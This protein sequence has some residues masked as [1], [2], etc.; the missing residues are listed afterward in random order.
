MNTSQARSRALDIISARRQHSRQLTESRRKELMASVEGLAEL[1]KEINNAGIAALHSAVAG[2]AGGEKL[3]RDVEGLRAKQRELLKS[4]GID[5]HAL[6]PQY[7]CEK[8]RDTGFLP[9]GEMCGCLHELI[10]RILREDINRNSPLELSTFDDFSLDYYPEKTEYY[11]NGD[12]NSAP[13]VRYP[14]RDAKYNLDVC[15]RFAQK[16]PECGADLLLLGDAGL[17]KTHLALAIANEVIARGYDVIYCSSA[18]ALRR[19]EEERLNRELEG[20]TLESLKKCSLLIF[21]DLG[22]EYVNQYTLSVLYDLI[23]SRRGARRLTVYTTNLIAE[24][25]MMRRYGE[26]IS[27]RLEGGCVMLPFTGDDIRI[28]LGRRA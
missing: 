23:N 13:V 25:A 27:S 24:G 17:G 3:T 11:P 1:E 18:A 2:N 8:C 14:R 19:I 12:K 16:F 20:G 10:G 28:K 7:S 4:C 6:E 15:R 21:D 22:A 5:E 26:K 9:T